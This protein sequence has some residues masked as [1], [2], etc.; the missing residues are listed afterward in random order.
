M[1]S[2]RQAA[3]KLASDVVSKLEVLQALCLLAL[4]DERYQHRSHSL[5]AVY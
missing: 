2:S 5:C 4:S 1:K 3:L